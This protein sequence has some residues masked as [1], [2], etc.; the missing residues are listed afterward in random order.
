MS[1]PGS[2][3]PPL[4]VADAVAL[5]FLNS[6]AT[7]VDTPVEWLASGADLLAWLEAAKL[8]PNEVI[9]GFRT[10]ALPG[11]LDAVAAQA[12]ALRE[13]FR[14]FVSDHQGKPIRAT[15]LAELEPLNRVLARDHEFGQIIARPRGQDS[16]SPSALEWVTQREWRSPDTLLLPIAKSMAQLVAEADFRDIKACEGSRCTVLFLDR[17]RSR[18][19]RWCS[20][21]LCGNR[22]KQ[23]AHRERLQREKH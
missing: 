1:D 19:R 3:L 11:E 2:R 8:A 4:F 14:G 17:T 5:D 16:A 23:S 22:A 10:G 18:A 13:W 15:A 7:P 6:I 20:M 21:S 9:E 12:R